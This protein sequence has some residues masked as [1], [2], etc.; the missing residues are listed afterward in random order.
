MHSTCRECIETYHPLRAHNNLLYRSVSQHFSYCVPLHIIHFFE[1]PPKITG[2]ANIT[3]YFWAGWPNSMQQVPVRGS[4]WAGQILGDRK[5]CCGALS[6]EPGQ[7]A[8]Y[9][10]SSYQGSNKYHQYHLKY[11]WGYPVPLVEKNYS[12]VYK[13][14]HFEI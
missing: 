5:A 12:T 1:I 14:Y 4:V 11:H 6:A 7:V 9:S 3:C 8:L 10:Q 13:I 2:S